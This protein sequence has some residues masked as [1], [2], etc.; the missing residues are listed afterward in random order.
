MPAGAEG[1]TRRGP[2]ASAGRSR[3]GWNDTRV[4]PELLLTSATPRRSS[5]QS[6]RVWASPLS[7]Q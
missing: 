4:K 1:P 3:Q 2:R 6:T 5:T 7:S